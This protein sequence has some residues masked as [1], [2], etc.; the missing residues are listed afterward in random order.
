MPTLCAQAGWSGPLAGLLTASVAVSNMAGTIGAGRLLHHGMRPRTLMWIGFSA[1]AAGAWLALS[2][3]TATATML[4]YLG[5]MLFSVFGGLVSGSLFALVSRLAPSD[6]TTSTT[7]GWM[8]Q[9]AAVGQMCGPPL[10]AWVAAGAGGWHWTWAITGAF[11]AVGAALSWRINRWEPR[12][13]AGTWRTGS[14]PR[15]RDLRR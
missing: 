10:V 11:C 5:A 8:L 1:M 14:A 9:W 4:R 7:V 13:A 15:T 2:T 3:T 12:L 6:R